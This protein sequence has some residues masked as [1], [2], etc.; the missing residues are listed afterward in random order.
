[1]TE[2]METVQRHLQRLTAS[3]A[4]EVAR[5][6]SLPLLETYEALVALESQGLAR[7]RVTH[8]R[9]GSGYFREWVAA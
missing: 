4:Q 5:A 2:N 1:M 6:T 9:V 3:T 8:D 7:V